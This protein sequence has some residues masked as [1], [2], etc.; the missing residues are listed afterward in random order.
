MSE[1]RPITYFGDDAVRQ[2]EKTEG[3]KLN[4]AQRRVVEEEGFVSGNYQDD[5]GISTSGVG[6]TGKWKGKSFLDT[7]NAHEQDAKSVIPDYDF[8]PDSL[9]AEIA[10]VAYRGDLRNKDGSPTKWSS[11]VN[12]GDYL[13]ASEELLN[14]NEYRERKS[15]G[16]DGVTRRLEALSTEL[17]RNAE[18]E[19]NKQTRVR[20]SKDHLESRLS[21]AIERNQQKICLL[22]TSPSPRDLSTS[23]MPSSA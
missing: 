23:R 3:V 21:A 20:R 15:I 12:Q 13:G 19:G 14:H 4:N 11:M 17:A 2:V 7:F 9:K 16:N 1:N 10:Q 8:L 6:Q 18:P 5:R 22:Y